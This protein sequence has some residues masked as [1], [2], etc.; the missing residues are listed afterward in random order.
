MVQ[1][2]MIAATLTGLAAI[3]GVYAFGGNA[4]AAHAVAFAVAAGTV[5]TVSLAQQC[6]RESAGLRRSLDRLVMSVMPDDLVVGAI[7][8][9]ASV[10][11]AVEGLPVLKPW[12]GPLLDEP[13]WVWAFHPAENAP[14]GAMLILEQEDLARLVLLGEENLDAELNKRFFTPDG[15]SLEEMWD[16]LTREV[17]L[18]AAWAF[19]QQPSASLVGV[20][21]YASIQTREL[22]AAPKT[23]DGIDV[24]RERVFGQADLDTL[25]RLPRVART[26]AF[27]ER[28]AQTR[29]VAPSA[30]KER[31]IAG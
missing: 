12:E 15:R 6:M 16:D 3:A 10:V 25:S 13:A 11:A 21:K 4:A 8:A 19:R 14:A 1:P 20:A 17:S 29:L 30:T 27:V 22:G 31:L 7:R 24:S 23:V 2:H 9:R 26:L 28:F 18:A 5:A